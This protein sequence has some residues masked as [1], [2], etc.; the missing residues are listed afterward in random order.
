MNDGHYVPTNSVRTKHMAKEAG[1][2]A[3]SVRLITMDRI[4]VFD[5][6]CLK[7]FSPKAIKFRKAF[8]DKA[9]EF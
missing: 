6:G 9:V 1:N 3:E 8:T 2:I 7:E 4:I 5:E